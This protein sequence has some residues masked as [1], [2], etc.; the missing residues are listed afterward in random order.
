MSDSY[1]EVT[2]HVNQAFQSLWVNCLLPVSTAHLKWIAYILFTRGWKAGCG[3]W[4][5]FAVGQMCK[6]AHMFG[7]QIHGLPL[8]FSKGEKPGS[9]PRSNRC[10]AACLCMGSLC[11]GVLLGRTGAAWRKWKVAPRLLSVPQNSSV[12][13]G[14]SREKPQTGLGVRACASF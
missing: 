2:Q 5:L 6:C 4:H 9:S 12:Q 7:M 11:L 13:N 14:N 1:R 10:R 3:V 8:A